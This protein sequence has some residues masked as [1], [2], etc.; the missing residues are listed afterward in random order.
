MTSCILLGEWHDILD[1][2]LSNAHATAY[3]YLDCHHTATI[4]GGRIQKLCQTLLQNLTTVEIFKFVKRLYQWVNLFLDICYRRYRKEGDKGTIADSLKYLCNKYRPHNFALEQFRGFL[5]RSDLN[6]LSFLRFHK[7]VWLFGLIKVSQH[8]SVRLQ[9]LLFNKS[10]FD[11][12]KT[13]SHW[14]R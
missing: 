5:I 11:K 14:T 9:Y 6:I 10:V 2:C 7:T 13:C 12:D 3:R 1:R 8:N 4:W